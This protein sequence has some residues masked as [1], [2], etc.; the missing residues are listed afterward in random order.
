MSFINVDDDLLLLSSLLLSLLL[1]SVAVVDKKAADSVAT[2]ISVEYA[3]A[4]A[5]RRL[6][7][8]NGSRK[9]ESKDI[10]SMISWYKILLLLLL[11][12]LLV[13]VT[14][15]ATFGCGCDRGVRNKS[16]PD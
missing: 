4:Y 8:D 12:V 11:L 16:L 10:S 9:E 15:C 14:G 5:I 2:Q 1:L 7:F 3:F 13:R 6:N